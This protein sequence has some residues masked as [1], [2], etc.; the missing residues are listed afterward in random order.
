MKP[1][2]TPRH[3]RSIGSSREFFREIH[4]AGLLLLPVFALAAALL[5]TVEKLA[6]IP[7]GTR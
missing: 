7:E 4:P 3:T 1:G 2:I 5:V 6:A